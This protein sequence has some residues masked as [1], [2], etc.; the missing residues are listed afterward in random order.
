MKFAVI[1]DH[2]SFAKDHLKSNWS[3]VSEFLLFLTILNNGDF[4]FE[5]K[6]FNAIIE[7]TLGQRKV[8][9]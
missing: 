3:N 9:G 4:F 1:W 5:S 6:I 8:K 2:L 7:I